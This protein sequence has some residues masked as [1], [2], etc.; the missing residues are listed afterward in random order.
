ML[1]GAGFAWPLGTHAQQPAIPVIG[2][3]ATGA[4]AEVAH[5]VT[6]FRDG[7][8]EVGYVEG[9]NVLIEYRWAENQRGRLPALA[10][11]LVHRKV[12]VIIATSGA[13]S[14]M[15]V[16]AATTT[17]PIIL[18]GGGD[19][20]KLGLIDDFSRPGGNATG[21][22]NISAELTAK[23]LEILR[24]LVPN[25]TMIAVLTNRDNPS[26][27]SQLKDVAA[28][29]RAMQQE[30]YVVNASSDRDIAEAFAT[31]VQHR[32]GALLVHCGSL[33]HQSARA[34][35][36]ARGTARASSNLSFPRIHRG[37]WSD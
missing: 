11:D 6:A 23:R 34:T 15:P 4:S 14:W 28:A 26:A 1:L 3:L 12:A 33:L 13:S 20:I 25:A 19:P 30:I 2:F 10:A 18:Q 29:G 16:M 27:E 31:L 9:Q 37:G 17:I 24:E 22:V 21:V 35:C 7:L 5:L 32:A 36:G 8:K